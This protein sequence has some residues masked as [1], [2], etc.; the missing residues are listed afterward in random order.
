VGLILGSTF[1][2]LV[3]GL[4]GGRFAAVPVGKWH[5]ML[6]AAQAIEGQVA[7]DAIDP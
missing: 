4:R 7:G 5:L 3:G 6:V 2:P 1:A